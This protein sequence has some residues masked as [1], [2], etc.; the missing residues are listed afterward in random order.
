MKLITRPMLLIGL[1]MA[2]GLGSLFSKDPLNFAGMS[3][4]SWFILFQ[5]VQGGKVQKDE[6]FLGN[7][8]KAG[9][10]GFYLANMGFTFLFLAMGFFHL[11]A[12][13]AVFLMAGIF[14]L[15]NLGFLIAFIRYER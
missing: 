5:N 8:G 15:M 6:R 11:S 2:V 10:I 4:I 12:T 7:V 1:A 3:F 9:Y 14:F 13:T